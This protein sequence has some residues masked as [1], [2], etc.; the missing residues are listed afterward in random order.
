MGARSSRRWAKPANFAQELERA[1]GIEPSTYSLGSN[2][3]CRQ[4]KELLAKQ[5]VARA[6]DQGVISGLQNGVLTG[7]HANKSPQWE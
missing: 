1:K 3:V 7:S 5:P 4:I 2:V 6:R